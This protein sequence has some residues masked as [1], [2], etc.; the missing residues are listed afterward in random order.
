MKSL[1]LLICGLLVW[2]GCSTEVTESDAEPTERVVCTTPELV[3]CT[4]STGCEQ[5]W[6]VNPCAA[7][8]AVVDGSCNAGNNA[9]LVSED[10][11]DGSWWC[12][13][14][15]DYDYASELSACVV[16]EVTP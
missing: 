7:N 13:V 1:K 2:T 15:M 6:Q 12:S 8:E 5:R 14:S 9:E 10:L 16:C 11:S 3:V 4:D